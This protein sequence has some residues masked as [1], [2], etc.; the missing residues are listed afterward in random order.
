MLVT[1]WLS[2]TSAM[3]TP[4]KN[5]D[6]NF[7]NKNILNFK[8]CFTILRNFFAE[9]IRQFIYNACNIML[10]NLFLIYEKR[11]VAF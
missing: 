3:R 6:G 4:E 1:A 5:A 10:V 2:S 8:G 9:F 11:L 7:Q